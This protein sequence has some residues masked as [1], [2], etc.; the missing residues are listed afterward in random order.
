MSRKL[1]FAS[2]PLTT[3][4]T[5]NTNMFNEVQEDTT[6]KIDYKDPLRALIYTMYGW[7]EHSQLFS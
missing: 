5:T 4:T 7:V 6:Q 1:Q 3:Y 2:W